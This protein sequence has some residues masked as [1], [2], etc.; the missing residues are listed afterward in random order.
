M[1][2]ILITGGQERENGFTLGEGKYYKA[3]KLLRLDTETGEIDEL[4]KINNG[5]KNYP[6]EHPNLQFTAGWVDGQ[7]LWLPT[8]TE[9]MLYSYP[10]LKL[11]KKYSHPC[12]HNI[13]HIRPFNEFLAV[14]STGL[15][16]VI[17]LNKESGEPIRYY[18][19]E[20]KEPW[21]R[22]SEHVDYRKIHSTRPHDG[23]PNFVFNIDD[24]LWV[25]RCAT[26]DAVCLED[27]TKKIDISRGKDISVHDGHYYEGKLIFTQVDGVLSIADP[28][29]KVIEEDINLLNIEGRK[30]AKGWCRGV[31]LDGDIIYVGFSKLRRTR[32]RKK[33]AWVKNIMTGTSDQLKAHVAAYD[34]KKRKKL[35]EWTF[36]EGSVDAIYSILPEPE[37]LQKV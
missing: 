21:H 13:H 15:D 23:H 12:F 4:L 34:I 22:F 3:A 33:V 20:G 27:T 32:N 28:A 11:I 2:K 25:T 37:Y 16:M 9:V 18:N 36:A 6:D 10:E 26:E 17:L 1:A 5:G 35:N 14:V 7:D 19:V 24:K 29:S 31:Y 30:E 8:D